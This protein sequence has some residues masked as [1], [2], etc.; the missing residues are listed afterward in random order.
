[1]K[2]CD[3][4]L[5]Y[6]ETSG[7]IRTYLDAK[8][9]Y[10]ESETDHEHVLIVP[11]EEDAVETRG[12]LTKHTV[13]SPILP[14][15]EPYRFFW[16]PGKIKH[17]LRESQPHV[18][19]LGSFYVAPWPAFSYRRDRDNDGLPTVVG[20]Y[21]HSDIADA[22]F[23]APLREAFHGWSEVVDW[24]G[25]RLAG[26]AEAGAASFVGSVFEKCDV[27][28]AASPAQAER[29]TEY[30]V[31]PPVEVVPLG[32]DLELFN[33]ARR[34]GR[35]RQSLGVGDESTML[36]YAGRLDS[37]K[38]PHVLLDAFE[39]LPEEL[40]AYLVMLGEGPLK[41]E[42][43]ERSEHNERVAVLPYETD[44]ARFA[45]LLASADVYVTAGPHETFALSVV[46]AQAC[47][48]PVVGVASGALVERVPDGL[49]LLGPVDDAG[50]VAENIARVA[51]QRDTM[52]E[53]A[54][55]HVQEAFSWDATFHRL[56]SIY[57]QAVRDRAGRMGH[58]S[59]L[60]APEA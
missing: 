55:R 13:A 4:T 56:L 10:L 41:E 37:E 54:R 6:T 20:G 58:E 24:L 16:R 52:G 53:A 59:P 35:L 45:E 19:E 36:I 14:G 39:Q 5:S 34:N 8:R 18:V 27:R 9:D 43:Q 51:R 44:P 38:R 3:I 26:A 25:D 48:L 17:V 29:L 21:F 47:G 22:Y 49:G 1:M 28:L 11:G 32:V 33:P 46:E 7:G 40:D 2:F 57:E 60:P 30:G 23:G 31:A 12:R 50:A 42:L 15:C